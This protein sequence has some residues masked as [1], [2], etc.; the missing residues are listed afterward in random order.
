MGLELS[1]G[2]IHGVRVV[3]KEAFPEL[4]NISRD[5]EAWV[6]DHLN[7]Q[8]EVV[9]WSLN[10]LRPAHDW[11]LEMISSFM[12]VLYQSGVKGYGPDKVWWQKSS[13]KGFQV[14]SFYKALLPSIGTSVPWKIIWKTKVPPRVRFFVWTA[15]MDR[16]L[17]VQN[18]RRR[19]VMVID[20]CYM[21]K[22]SGESTDHLLLHCPIVY[23]LWCCIFSLFGLQWV[24]P[25][26]V[27]DLLACWGEGRGKS[28]IQVL[29]NSI[30]HGIFWVLWCERNSRAF[31]GRERSVL[32]LKW[33]LIRTLMDW[34]NAAGSTLFSSI[35]DFLDFCMLYLCALI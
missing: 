1:F 6:V 18:L 24:M 3:L 16:I 34:S 29:W 27:L 25:K 22:A 7:Y 12:E 31:E 26:G 8:N 13:G 23:D 15:A 32:E 9:T 2:L 21:C 33:F 35:F 5:K 28:K 17:T 20:W 30:P 10:F 11:E 4:Y 19:H 14:K